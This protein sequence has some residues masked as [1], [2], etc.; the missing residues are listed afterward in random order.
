MSN[1]IDKPKLLSVQLIS[2]MAD[3]KGITFNYITPQK[4]E[5]YFRSRDN[6]LRTAAYRKNYQKNISGKNKDK[7]IN[8]DFSYL[9]ELSI[10]DMHLRN[11]ISKMC[12]DIEH[13]MK[14]RL[15]QDVENDSSHNGY[16]LVDEF[17]NL[18]AYSVNQLEIKSKS[19]FTGDLIC[20]Y[21]EIQKLRN[22]STG[23]LE[24]KIVAFDCPV[25]VL[26]ELLSFG[27]FIRFYQFCYDK[28][29]KKCISISI[30]NL[31]KSLRNGCAHNNCLISDLEHGSSSPPPE[32][33]NVV[34]NIYCIN[35]NQR[36]K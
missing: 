25:W 1:R 36:Q 33:S 27:E 29:S 3:E 28:L 18:N 26:V 4:A 20:K 9:Q 31:V 10:L 11:L 5:E 13:A 24:N 15:L 2:K 30:I 32:I 14:V 12:F 16:D 34:A 22:A 17:L 21:F 7:Y 6:Y 23:K 8:Q 35:K 19:P